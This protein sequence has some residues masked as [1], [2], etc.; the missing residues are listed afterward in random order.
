MALDILEGKSLPFFFYGMAY[1]GGGALE[2]F[3]GAAAFAVFG[4]SELALKLCMLLLWTG[5]ALLFADLCR[6]HLS[7]SQSG[8]AVFF[9]SFGTPFFLEWSVKARGGFAETVF[10][11]VILLWIANPPAKLGR[12][13]G[14]QSYLFGLSSGVALWASEMIL[15]L[16]PLAAIWM[17]QRAPGARRRLAVGLGLGLLVGL[18]PLAMYNLVHQGANFKA[19]T[20]Y[21]LFS[22]PGRAPLTGSQMIL[23]ADFVLGPGWWLFTA[24]LLASAGRLMR[25]RGAAGV[26][27]GSAVSGTF[28]FLHRVFSMLSIQ[29]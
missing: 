27:S 7:G 10:F 28:P 13:P 24:F 29:V 3:L 9:F 2:A 5:T 23:A 8:W 20:V 22:R 19:S 26:C 1:N 6:R 17:F 16:V 14:L 12:W 15:P 4:P 21:A 11:T 25:E 18:V